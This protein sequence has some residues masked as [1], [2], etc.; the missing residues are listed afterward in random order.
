M[1]QRLLSLPDPAQIPPNRSILVLV[2]DLALNP[3]P[4]DFEQDDQ[5]VQGP[6]TQFSGKNNNISKL[7]SDSCHLDRASNDEFSV[8]CLF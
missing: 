1:L 8:E 4:Q 6:Q 7:M 2:R 5:L 3:S